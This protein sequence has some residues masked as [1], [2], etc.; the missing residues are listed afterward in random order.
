LEALARLM[1]AFGA[2]KT[3]QRLGPRLLFGHAAPHELR[4]AEIDVQADL[5]VDR[6]A[7][8]AATGRQ[9]EQA[10]ESRHAVLAA[11]VRMDVT[12]CA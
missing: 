11:A 4:G 2:S 10:P 9:P 6:V 8:R 3:P 12:V 5:I 7:Q 1:K